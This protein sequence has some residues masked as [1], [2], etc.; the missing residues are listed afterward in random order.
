MSGLYTRANLSEGGLNA[1]E[2]LQKLYAPQIQN[3]IGLFAYA[4]IL[5]SRISSPGQIFA[6]VNSPISDLSGN[7][8]KRTK[9]ITNSYTFSNNNEVWFESVGFALDQRED[10]EV[11]GAVLRYSVNGSVVNASVRGFGTGYKVVDT[12]GVE[13]PSYPASVDVRV[14]GSESFST[15]AVVRVTVNSDGRLGDEIE[16]IDGGSGYQPDEFLTPLPICQGQDTPQRNRCLRYTGPTSLAK[17]YPSDSALIRNTQYTYMVRFSDSDGF[18]LYDTRV[19]DWIYLGESYDETTLLTGSLVLTRSDSI[20]PENLG[21]LYNLNARSFFYSYLSPFQPSSNLASTL[22]SVSDSV[23][24]INNDLSQFVQNGR[25]YLFDT[26]P[27]NPLGIT[28]NVFEGRN[29]N[30]DHRVVFRDPDSVL[31]QESIDF[32]TLR[33]TLSGQNQYRVEDV[34]VPGIWLFAGDKYQRVFS[35]DDK[36]FTS[37]LGRKYLSPAIYSEDGNEL[38]S[39]G[40]L[41]YSISASFR[42]PVSE[43]TKGFN[44]EIGTLVQTIGSSGGFVF[45]RPLTVNTV[46]GVYSWPI[47]SYTDGSG[48]TKDARFLAI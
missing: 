28:F 41:K 48:N 29:I 14:I 46:S 19:S 38:P 1:S 34:T 9:F 4:S 26:N 37:V 40:S 8:S 7:V 6:L 11:D 39:S 24:L 36:P 22:K 44:T 23:E 47:L 15:N 21:Q 33:D 32:F 31:D 18:F 16:V 12:S 30:S 20:E 2:A 45:H 25:P 5:R 42:N 3:D 27:D 10:G 35:S 17:T 43:I 13:V